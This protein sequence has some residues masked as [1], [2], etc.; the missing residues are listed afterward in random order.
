MKT[1]S[2]SSPAVSYKDAYYRSLCDNPTSYDKVVDW[3][4][5]NNPAAKRNSFNQTPEEFACSAVHYCIRAVVY[6]SSRPMYAA[7]GM[8]F[9]VRA[10]SNPEWASY[11]KVVLTVQL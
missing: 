6:G 2:A 11:H 1:E 9:A 3:I 7:T 10:S 8:A 5:A 4:V